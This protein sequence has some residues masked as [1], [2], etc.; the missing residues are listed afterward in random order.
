MFESINIGREKKDSNILIRIK[1]WHWSVRIWNFCTTFPRAGVPAHKGVL[2]EAM[3][4]LIVKTILRTCPQHLNGCLS[5]SICVSSDGCCLAILHNTI[6][7]LSPSRKTS[8]HLLPAL[9]RACRITRVGVRGDNKNWHLTQSKILPVAVQDHS[10]QT[11][12]QDLFVLLRK[13]GCLG[14]WV[15]SNVW[16]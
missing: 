10:D 14:T 5:D 3:H 16:K 2:L 11:L 12:V 13:P 8:A 6:D 4:L 15:C 9:R 7:T 1:K